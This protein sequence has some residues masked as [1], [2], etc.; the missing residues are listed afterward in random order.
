M[1][2]PDEIE[3][4]VLRHLDQTPTQ[5][6]SEMLDEWEVQAKQCVSGGFLKRR[7]VLGLLSLARSHIEREEDLRYE[8]K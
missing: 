2:P 4:A 1:I 7:D 5:V 8:S 3:R 6:T